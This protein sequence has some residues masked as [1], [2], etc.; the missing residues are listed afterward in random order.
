[1]ANLFAIGYCMLAF[2]AQLTIGTPT[3][4]YEPRPYTVSV[5]DSLIEEVRLQVNAFR[6]SN[7]GKIPD[8]LDGPPSSD[9]ESFAHYWAN[10]YD[11]AGIE[12][13]INAN[14]SHFY[15]TVPPGVNYTEP[16]DLHFIHQK[17]SRVDA[18]PILFLHGWPSTSLEW[19]KI[20]PGLVNPEDT[21]D[22][23]FHVVAPDFPAYGFSP[24]FSAS[25]ENVTRSTYAK[26]FTDLMSQLGYDRFILY[27]T[28]LGFAVANALIV[29]YAD[30]VINHITDFY[31]VFPTEEDRNRFNANLTTPAETTYIKASDFFLNELSGYSTIHRTLPLAIAYTL[32]D[33]PVGFLA[34]Y[35]NIAGVVTDRPF[36]PRDMVTNTL[37]LWLPGVYGNIRS[38]KEMFGVFVPDKS[39]TVPTSVLQFGGTL[40]YPQLEGFTFAVGRTKYLGCVQSYC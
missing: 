15:T 12:A 36:T 14:F 9:I 7:G 6:N 28:D 13:E 33:S 31:Y 35:Y 34:W 8:W 26:I 23:A 11:W 1:M 17:S 22:P 21:S 24:D 32:N 2:S 37:L 4:T 27:S 20:I 25:R 38:Y 30:Y 18:T 19:G 10:E 3:T 29:D 40:H 39:F 5:N 16:V